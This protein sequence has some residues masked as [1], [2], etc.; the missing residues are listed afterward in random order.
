MIRLN[1]H[2]LSWFNHNR[3]GLR[4]PKGSSPAAEIFIRH[5]VHGIAKFHHAIT[6][7]NIERIQALLDS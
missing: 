3:Q 2:E 5:G 1:E 7:R 4:L 6:S